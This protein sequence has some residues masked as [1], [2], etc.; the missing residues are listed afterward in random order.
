VIDEQGQPLGELPVQEA[1]RLARERGFDLVEVAPNA[2]PPVCKLL[3]FGR[4][5]YEKKRQER[6][7]RKHQHRAAIREMRLTLKISEHDFQVKLTKIKELLVDGDRVKVSVR[8]RGRE[9]LHANLGMK[10]FERLI[11]DTAELSKVE[12]APKQEEN[13]IYAL[14]V[15][16]KKRRE[17]N[18]Q[19]EDKKG[20]G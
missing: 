2:K 19:A 9:M 20:L 12:N 13:T 14:F 15:P 7:S 17:V 11:A 18:E 4:Y 5:M 3:D 6:E 1:R 10:I 16:D 8:L